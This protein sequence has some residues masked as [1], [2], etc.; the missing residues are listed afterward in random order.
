MLA[1]APGK[2]VSQF[3]C[4]RSLALLFPKSLNPFTSSPN[5]TSTIRVKETG[6]P[7]KECPP[8]PS[9]AKT[10]RWQAVPI[11]ALL[12]MQQAHLCP[13]SDHSSQD[14]HLLGW[15]QQRAG[16]LSNRLSLLI[17]LEAGKSRVKGLTGSVSGECS[18]PLLK[19]FQIP[20]QGLHPHDLI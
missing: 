20:S 19:R 1:A 10:G 9:G 12:S 15:L 4:G 17:R 3:S 7:G 6:S 5:P 18:L 16:G 11:C 8:H 14:L 2:R 13:G